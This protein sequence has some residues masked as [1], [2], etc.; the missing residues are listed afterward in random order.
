VVI[1][2]DGRHNSERWGKLTA[3]VFLRYGFKVRRKCIYFLKYY[4]N[5]GY[6]DIFKVNVK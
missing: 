4:L 3:G 2:F 1:G 5:A 6:V